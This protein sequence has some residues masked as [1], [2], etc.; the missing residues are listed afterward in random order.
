MLIILI[1][2][3]K[4][5]KNRKRGCL[6]PVLF[7]QLKNEQRSLPLSSVFLAPSIWLITTE[8]KKNLSAFAVFLLSFPPPFALKI[9]GKKIGLKGK[10]WVS[11]QTRHYSK[12]Q[13]GKRISEFD[14]CS[15]NSIRFN[16]ISIGAPTSMWVVHSFIKYITIDTILWIELCFVVLSFYS[17]LQSLI[18]GNCQLR[19]ARC[20]SFQSCFFSSKVPHNVL[21][22]WPCSGLFLLMSF[23]PTNL[24]TPKKKLFAG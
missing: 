6:I 15:K 10:K 13:R 17:W 20:D 21:C 3:Q 12:K 4:G 19:C 2:K 5:K 11:R 18:I 8:S 24:L 14:S 16:W 7:S 1:I 9:K 23:F 22:W